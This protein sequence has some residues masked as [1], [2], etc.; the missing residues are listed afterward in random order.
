[1]RTTNTSEG[2]WDDKHGVPIRE[3]KLSFVLRIKTE[4]LAEK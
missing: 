2:T 1:M 4:F 3:A